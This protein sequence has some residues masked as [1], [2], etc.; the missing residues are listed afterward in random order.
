MDGLY[1]YHAYIFNTNCET[2][3]PTWIRTFMRENTHFDFTVL[4][5]V[6]NGESDNI[7]K[8]Y[9]DARGEIEKAFIIN[10]SV[11]TPNYDKKPLNLRLKIARSAIEMF[12]SLGVKEDNIIDYKNNLL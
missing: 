6:L 4:K 2:S 3:T 12:K 10:F 11:E 8:E 1:G 7:L 9:F 5:A